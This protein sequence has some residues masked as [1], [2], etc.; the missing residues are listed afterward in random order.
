MHVTSNYQFSSLRKNEE[1]S[2]KPAEVF[3]PSVLPPS[4]SQ[5][6]PPPHLPVQVGNA[7]VALRGSVELSDLLNSEALC[8]VLPYGGSQTIAHRQP[9]AVLGF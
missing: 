3:L 8:E 7:A 9:H 4:P 2:G 5:Y 1:A 6:P